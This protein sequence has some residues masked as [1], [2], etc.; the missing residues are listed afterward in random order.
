M[1]ICWHP[2][3]TYLE[4]ETTGVTVRR[5]PLCPAITWAAPGITPDPLPP[6]IFDE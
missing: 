3:G 5:C 4:A 1:R 2:D 6:W